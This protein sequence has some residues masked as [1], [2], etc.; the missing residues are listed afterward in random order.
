MVMK[1]KLIPFY[2]LMLSILMLANCGQDN[3]TSNPVED[4]LPTITIKSIRSEEGNASKTFDFLVQ[5]SEVSEKIVSVDFTT[6]DGTAISGVDYTMT[7]GTLTFQPGDSILKV[8]V[9]IITDTD[10]EED[11]SFELL[12][13]NAVNAILWAGTAKGT[14]LNDDGFTPLDNTGYFS[15]ESY[16]GYSLVWEEQFS[17]NNIDTE[18]WTHETGNSGWGNNESQNYTARPDNSWVYDSKLIIEAKKEAFGGSQY[19]SARMISKGKKEF[20]YGRIDIRAKLPEGQGIWPALWMLGA[21]IESVGWP[22]CGELDIMELVG[23]EPATTHG[24]IHWSNNS[25]S[26]SYIGGSKTLSSGK[27]SDEYHVFSVIW[28]KSKIKWLLDDQEFYIASTNESAKSEFNYPF[29]FIMN[30]AVGGNWPGYPDA[31]TVFPQR[32]Y[33]DYIRVFQQ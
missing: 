14:I 13:S 23:H 21:N 6:K 24:T 2:I 7:S 31:T 11:K 12:L 20:R 30:I 33:V 17:G 15:A 27:L 19:T 10:T 25:N 28:E 4:P 1:S 29:F 3:D 8:P 32:M 9:T 22:S 26:H 18:S 16:A 5:L